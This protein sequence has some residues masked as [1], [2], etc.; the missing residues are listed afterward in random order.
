MTDHVAEL[1][2]RE[3]LIPRGSTVLCAVSGGADSIYLLHRLYRLRRELDFTL[4]AAHYDHQLRGAESAMDLEFVQQ[5]LTLCCGADRLCRPDGT[6]SLLPPVSLITGTGD[7]A[8]RAAREKRGLEE[9]A[10]IMRYAFLRETAHQV[11]ASRIATAHNANDNAETLLLHLV[12][13]T[14]LRGLGGIA[15]K[16]QD[17]IRPLL[18]TTRDEI[19]SYLRYWGLPWREDPSNR[20]ESY[21]RNRLRHRVLPEL[22]GISPQFLAHVSQT[23]ARLRADEAYLTHLAQQALELRAEPDGGL[24]L[25]AAQLADLPQPLAIRAARL[26]LGRMNGGDVC[27]T[28]AHLEALVELCR[29]TSP[30]AQLNLP[31]GLVAQRVYEAVLL[32]RAASVPLGPVPLSLTGETRAGE[33][34]IFCQEE[35][36]AGQPQGPWELWLSQEKAP[37]PLVRHRKTGDTLSPPGRPTKTLKKWY[38][39]EKIPAGRR[40]QLPVLDWNGQVAAVAGLGPDRA[41]LPNVGEL[42]WHI[43]FSAQ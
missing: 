27:C 32:T 4:V 43:R 11:G 17:L 15:P 8:G 20:D 13:G 7:V 30:S 38:V 41:Y 10:R 19:E 3:D 37:A 14:G 6:V 36:Y 23:A 34:R 21:T 1:I 29:S 39:D 2:E 24:S 5:F 33:W 42:C 28:A 25:S 18:T 9:M 16:S 35:P 12:R 31:G 26:L 22:E 40:D